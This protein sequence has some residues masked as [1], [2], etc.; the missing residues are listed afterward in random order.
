MRGTNNIRMNKTVTLASLLLFFSAFSAY[1]QNPPRPV[2][3][4][5]LATLAFGAFYQ[6]GAGTV[7]VDYAG[8]R[9]WTGGIITLGSYIVSPAVLRITGNLGTLV[10]LIMGPDITMNGDG[11]GTLTLHLDPVTDPTSP[12]VLT[13]GNPATVD[14]HIGG[15]IDVPAA[16]PRGSY[17]GTFTIIFNQD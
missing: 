11:G 12:F 4:T 15:T 17:S 6:S 8:T 5:P 16:R 2:T 3:V 1:A 14:L 10:T 7:S 9:T 13:G